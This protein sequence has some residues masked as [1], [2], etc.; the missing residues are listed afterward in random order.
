MK[1]S[2][3]PNNLIMYFHTKDNIV[4]QQLRQEYFFEILKNLISDQLFKYDLFVI[5]NQVLIQS[6][7]CFKDGVDNTTTMM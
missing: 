5:H 2:F 4:K 6:F 7:F 1:N 3:E